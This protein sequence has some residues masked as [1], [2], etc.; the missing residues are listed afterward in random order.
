MQKNGE[1]LTW[2]A[3]RQKFL[4]KYFPKS[5]IAQK[6]AQFLSLYQG[7]MTVDEYVKKFKSLAKYFRFF[8]NQVDEDYKCERFES[9]LH[10]EIKEV[11]APT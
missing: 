11:V 6:E 7:N 3:F 9:G 2:E 5:A 10:Y 8:S 1:E 4:D